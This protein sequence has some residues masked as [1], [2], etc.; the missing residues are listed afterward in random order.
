MA[1]LYVHIPFCRSKC[2]Y[3]DFY[4]SASGAEDMDRYADA[5][6]SEWRLRKH[7]LKEVPVTTIYFG[8]GT[9]SLMPIPK[10]Q[11]IMAA[12][13]DDIDLA[14][15]KEATIEANPEDITP[16]NV[17][18]Y[19]QTGFNRI[20]VGI[21]SF[22]QN[23]LDA[24]NRSH[25]PEASRKALEILSS[26]G[27]NYSADLI[28]GL[29]GQT[30]DDWTDNLTEL[31]SYNPPH[32]STY[33]LSYE[34]GTRLYAR[35]MNRLVQ[36]A[37]EELAI[38]MFRQLCS[39]ADMAGYHHYEISNLA[40]PG[41]E[42]KHNSSY[43]NYSP[44]IGLGASAHSF[45][46]LTRRYNPPSIRKYLQYIGNGM[47]AYSVDEENEENRFNDYIITSLRTSYGFD[48]DFAQKRFG[49]P[50]YAQFSD[51]ARTAIRKGEL[52]ITAAGHLH[53][54]RANWLTADAVMRELII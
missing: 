16:E 28:Y 26:T 10:L 5:I 53:I 19:R 13:S 42:A 36:E 38:N 6:I 14:T 30:I 17:A 47:P 8:G 4:S 52:E 22:H 9:P 27:I 48:R 39:H 49:K 2:A 46:G 44:Y 37:S 21:Q 7:E 32:I 43:W 3:C 33:L 11:R 29:P 18:L 12:L 50:L 34:P 20:S 54:P 25:T 51:N 41:Y 15:V 45:D 23:E 1:G 31:L 35:L 40:R 24:V